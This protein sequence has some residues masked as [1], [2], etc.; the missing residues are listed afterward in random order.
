MKQIAK[1]LLKDI[2]LAGGSEKSISNFLSEWDNSLNDSRKY[3]LAATKYFRRSLPDALKAHR[4][5]FQQESRGF[6]EDAFHVMW[7]LLSSKYSLTNFLEIGVYRGQTISLISLIG[8][9][10]GNPVHVY[11]ISPFS[12]VGDSVSTYLNHIDYQQDTY[13]N[14]TFFSLE[15]PELMKAY[16][17]DREAKDLIASKYWDC[18]YIDGSHDFEIVLEDWNLCSSHIRKG[19]IIVMD[20]SSFFTQA[21]LPFYAFK[22]HEGPSKVAEM[23]DKNRFKEVL[24]VGHN[25]V[26]ERVL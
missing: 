19:G 11:G 23:V 9:L 1:A 17:T 7:Y 14:F 10:K 26:F 15:K 13:K 22:G 4:F 25:R 5:Y 3:Y 8:K 20:D 2:S 21:K 16:S 24:R 12:S 18:I 6:G